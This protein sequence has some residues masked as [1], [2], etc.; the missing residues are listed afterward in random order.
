MLAAQTKINKKESSS[1]RGALRASGVMAFAGLGDALLYPVL[2]V[3]GKELGFSVFFIGVLL[4]INRFVRILTNTHIANLVKQIGMRNM[5]LITSSLAVITTFMYGLKLGLISFLIARILWGLS[6]SGLKIATL[7]YASQAKK[8]TGLA[9][10]LSQSIKSLGALFVLW[11]GPIVIMEYGIQN[12]LFIVAS[13]SLLGI[14]LACSL[15]IIANEKPYNKVRN[16]ITFYPSAMN[17][18]VLILSISIDGVLVVTLAYLLSSNSMS[19]S[20]LL[21]LLGFYLLLKRL[22]VILFSFVG[23]MLSLRY[24]PSKLFIIAV[25]WCLIALLLIAVNVTI[26]GIILAFLFNTIVVTFSPLVAIKQQQNALQSISSVSTWWDLG[27]A[28]GAFVGIYAIELLGVQNLYLSLC[29]AGT[30]LFMNYYIKNAK[31]SYTTI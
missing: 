14:V 4:S 24:S 22:F 26:L 21:M 30:I 11:F 25:F 2:P 20:Q 9:F 27:A 5:L 16:R 13:I 15:P 7:K 17:L 29:M 23:G 6:Y 19:S 3:Y 18:L 28:I 8:K 1:F 12:G 10:G 31:S